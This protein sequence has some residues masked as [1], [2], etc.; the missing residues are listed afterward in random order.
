MP[1]IVSIQ[2]MCGIADISTC[3][4]KLKE[5]Y[6]LEQTH[7]KGRIKSQKSRDPYFGFRNYFA[8]FQNRCSCGAIA[9]II[10]QEHVN[11]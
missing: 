1:T 6:E 9:S 7:R 2:C 4:L 8:K 3:E 5:K 10:Y 11:D